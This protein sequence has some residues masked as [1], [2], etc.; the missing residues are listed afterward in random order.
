M[1]EFI[2]SHGMIISGAILL[3]A[4]IFIASEKIQ[5][6]VVALVGASLTMLLGLIPLS[7]NL[8]HNVKGVFEYVDFEVIF[9][10]IGMMIIVNI[11]SRSGV[12]KWLAINL[13]K[14]TKGHPKT[15][16]FALAAFTAIASAFLDN[17]TTVVLMMPITFV[18]AKEFETDPVPFL[19]T[20]V[21]ASNIGGTATLIGDPPNII[22]GTRAGLSFMNFVQEL[23]PIVFLIF[24]VSIGV[25]I[26]LFRKGLKTT[27]EKMEHVANLDNSK[28]ITNKNLMIRSVITLGL[29]ILGFVT[30]DITHISAYVFAVSGASFLLLFEKPKEI[31]RDVEWLTIFFFI[32]LFIIIGGF[33]ANGGIKFLADQLIVLT[34]GSLELA[35]MVI[36]WASGIL[37]GII[38]NIPYTA[39]MAPLI[40]ELINPANPNAMTGA[41]H[42]LW[43]ALSLGA[44]LGGNL[45]IIGAAANVLVSETSESRGHKISFL[46]FMKYGA[47]ITFISLVLS[48]FYLYFRYLR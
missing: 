1:L 3:I 38:D 37:S 23:T 40:S 36:L 9:L 15:V 48:S 30:H 25:L 29:V 42:A 19:I 18:I 28:T 41:T 46:R 24:M 34:H 31:Y 21:L 6:S 26:F 47:L 44:C 12:F 27:P 22:I 32:G 2:H 14:L 10:L 33:E 20:E 17:V 4:Y 35:T 8:E 43:W 39:T 16:L 5:K 45:T 7:L 11:A 13:L